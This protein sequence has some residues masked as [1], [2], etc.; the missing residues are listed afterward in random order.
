MKTT[1][2]IAMALSGVL[3][4]SGSYADD[5]SVQENSIRKAAR[6][7]QQTAPPVSVQNTPAPVNQVAPVL[8]RPLVMAPLP[9]LAPAAPLVPMVAPR[10]LTPP[11]LTVNPVPLPVIA[12]IAPPVF[13]AM[14]ILPVITPPL[15]VIPPPP[16]VL[17]PPPII[18]VPIVFVPP[19][20]IYRTSDRRLKTNIH[21][22]G[23]HPRGF[24][25]YEYDYVWGEHAVGVMA[26]E[27]MVS[28]PEAVLRGEDG[29]D[30]VDY[31]KL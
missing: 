17:L 28:M 31:S 7:R 8:T 20:I 21:R 4:A 19:P 23:T 13:T 16:L 3:V 25:I 5:L 10:L 30:R 9:V 12:P 29:Y 1:Q 27:V 6:V 14:P 11:V 22:I 18:T 15:I 26:D 2:L 24:G